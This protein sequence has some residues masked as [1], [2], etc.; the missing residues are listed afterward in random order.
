MSTALAIIEL[1]EEITTAI[2]EGKT[3][4]GVFID[5]KKAFDTVDHNI[6]VKKLEHY[7]IRGLAKNW[8]CSYLENRRQYV[9]INDSNSECLDVKC[10]VP[11]GSIL[12]PA[13]FILYVNDMCNVSKSLKSILFTDD[14]NLFYAGKDLIGVNRPAFG[15]TVPHFHQMSR[16]PAKSADVPHFSK[17]VLLFFSLP[18][19]LHVCLATQQSDEL[20]IKIGKDRFKIRTPTGH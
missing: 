5:L 7:G 3:T 1:V 16:G 15:G 4:V 10:G 11:Q 13:L 9:C 8:V 14:T 19:I 20:R 17:M 12:G 6:L 18:I 2:D